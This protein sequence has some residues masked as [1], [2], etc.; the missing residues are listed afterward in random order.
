MNQTNSNQNK[1]LL[2]KFRKILDQNLQNDQF[3]VNML[4]SE[5]G[6]SISKLNRI[7]KSATGKSGSQF[8]RERVDDHVW[9]TYFKFAFE[10]NPWDKVVSWYYWNTRNGARPPLSRYIQEH[11]VGRMKGFELYSQHGE[12]VVDRVFRYEAL[13]EA[14]NEIAERLGL[15]EPPPLPHRHPD[16]PAPRGPLFEPARRRA[17]ARVG[18]SRTRRRRPLT[19][20]SRASPTATRGRPATAGRRRAAR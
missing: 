12:I 1:E 14:M 7:L 8:I 9:D 3:G 19:R 4:A 13:Q 5:A 2:S 11:Q 10:R 16:R 15:A 17:L 20:E 6:L 18:P